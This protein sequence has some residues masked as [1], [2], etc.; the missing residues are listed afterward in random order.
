MVL[1]MCL[2][3]RSCDRHFYHPHLVYERCNRVVWGSTL[4]GKEGSDRLGQ[5]CG[6]GPGNYLYTTMGSALG[7]SY[8][9]HICGLGIG[10]KT[11]RQT[12][13]T[14]RILS[15]CLSNPYLQTRKQVH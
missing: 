10:I 14:R 12:V 4:L 11:I 9:P 13:F 6:V 7:A 5:L 1:P 15:A 8:R 2:E 3:R